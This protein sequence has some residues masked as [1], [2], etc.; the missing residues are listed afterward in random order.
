MVSGISLDIT[1]IVDGNICNMCGFVDGNFVWNF[2]HLL[3]VTR[4]SFE[5]CNYQP[6]GRKRTCGPVVAVERSNQ[7]GL[8]VQKPDNP[9]HQ[10]VIFHSV[11]W[12]NPV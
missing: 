6:S 8:V 9:I 3:D 1:I 12:Y 10:I 2:I 5:K 11:D 4:S 7:L